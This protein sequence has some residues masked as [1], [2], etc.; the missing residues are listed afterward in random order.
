MD[1]GATGCRCE[2]QGFSGVDTDYM[3]ND[4]VILAATRRD[5][6]D[7]VELARSKTGRVFRKRILK[8]DSDFVHPTN[9]LKKVHVDQQ[10]AASLKRNF[11]SGMCDT[12]QFPIVGD[13]NQHV[14]DPFRNLGE[15]IGLTYDAN[16]VYA[17][18]D[19]RKNGDDVGT[20]ILGASA[21]M[22]L[23]YED[24][25]TGKRVGPTLLHVAGTNRPYITN[26]GAFEEIVAAS[27]KS[28]ADTSG[29][30]PVVLIPANTT[31]DK[32]ELS[33]ALA[34][35]KDEHGID[36]EALQAAK[37]PD[38]TELIT[39]LSNVLK[40]A[41]VQPQ[42]KDDD[43]VVLGDVAS[44]VIELAEEKVALSGKVA[45][46]EA[47]AETDSQAK[48]ERE[49]DDLVAAGRVLPKQRDAMVKLSRSDRET[50][51]ALVPADSI[52]AL[53]ALGV[54]TFDA[55]E[56]SEKFKEDIERLSTLA[57]SF[58]KKK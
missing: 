40:D 36:V 48:A 28:L 20:I 42:K 45:V 13:D 4:V 35:L 31:E 24:T 10:F 33:E 7:Y 8:M 39:A 52:V 53:S 57:N 56:K 22:S 5:T 1:I 54:D 14:E 30:K 41:G 6:G 55:P 34:F 58:G 15:V 18:I 11:D 25:Q 50:F 27:G 2:A 38:T 19:V 17:D 47:Q 23:D 12:V 44:A 46:L 29:D 16:G 26:L 37:A 21:L 51:D 9:P 43:E 32:M 3:N 49:V